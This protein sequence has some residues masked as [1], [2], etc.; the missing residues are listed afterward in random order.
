MRTFTITVTPVND[1]PSFVAGGDV[2]VGEDA[3]AETVAGWATAIS[4]GPAD[5]S[6]QTLSFQVSN[7]DNGLFAVQPALSAAGA[8]SFTVAAD[9]NGQAL[10]SV[11]LRD[12]GGVADG[13]DDTSLIRT[14]TITVTPVNDQPGAVAGSDTVTEDAASLAVDLRVLVADVETADANL[15]YAIVSGPTV[16]AGVLT[17]TGTNGVFSFAPAPDFNGSA[18]FTYQVSDR[19]DPDGCAPG[20]GCAAALTSAVRTFAITVAAANDAPTVAA[21]PAGVSVLEDGSAASVQIDGVDVETAAADLLVTVTQ[22]PAKG[23]LR[24]VGSC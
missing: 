17:A 16:A 4:A 20:P 3:G 11:F 7:D 15:S 24:R 22:V 2:T 23:T 14:F 10:V 19:G 12:D 21:V 8:P 6:G 5:E 13:G 9:A 1:A 18:S